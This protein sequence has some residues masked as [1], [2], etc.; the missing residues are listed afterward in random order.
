MFAA[1][2]ER[3]NAGSVRVG[4]ELERVLTRLEESGGVENVILDDGAAL[5]VLGVLAVVDPERVGCGMGCASGAA[6]S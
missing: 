2:D 4:I 1:G 6:A 5:D 3:C